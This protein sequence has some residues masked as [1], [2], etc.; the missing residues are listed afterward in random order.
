MCFWEIQRKMGG[1]HGCAPFK[2]GRIGESQPGAALAT[3]LASGLPFSAHSGL[4]FEARLE[5]ARRQPPSTN[6]SPLSSFPFCRSPAILP[7]VPLKVG[8][9]LTLKIR[10]EEHTSELQSLRHL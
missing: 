9:Q 2:A 6:P 10:S 4:G 3:S 5:A 8:D 1:A 7:P